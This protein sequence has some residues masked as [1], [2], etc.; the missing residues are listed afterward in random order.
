MHNLALAYTDNPEKAKQLY[1][2]VLAIELRVQPNH[3]ITFQ[4]MRNLAYVYFDLGQSDSA[5]GLLRSALEGRVR[6]LGM[7]H[8]KTQD[9]I[10]D[11]FDAAWS[12]RKHCEQLV[13]VLEQGQERA[14]RELGPKSRVTTSAT[15]CLSTFLVLLGRFDEATALENGLP[16]PA[17]REALGPI[18]LKA[19]ARLALALRERGRFDHGR[20]LME[21]IAAEAPRLSTKAPKADPSSEQVR[22]LA[23][24]L[25]GRWPGLAP[26]ISRA[27]RPPAPFTIEAPFRAASPVADGRIAPGEY[28]PAIEATFDGDT[29][30]GRVPLGCKPKTP[31]D[32]SMR[33]YTAYT[34]RSLFL[35]FQVRDQVIVADEQ[36]ARHPWANDSVAVFING[37]QVANDFLPAAA[38]LYPNGSREGFQIGA[39]ARAH[40]YTN[41]T[42]TDADRK[43]GTS[44]TPDG[45]IVEFEIPLALIDTRDGPEYVPATSGSE[46]LVNFL[47][48]DNDA[49]VNVAIDRGIFWAEDPP[50]DPYTGGE[51]FWTVALRLVPKHAGP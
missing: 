27:A 13:L 44:R 8:P 2:Q 1:E 12:N 43:V 20:R 23:Q 40:Q 6:I 7:L 11:F 39:D 16:A 28:G 10:C 5:I 48:A 24:F 21:E 25:L 41:S 31:D 4:T 50:L 49:P 35:A 18:E 3:P 29:N 45:Y 32:L 9:S 26:G 33:L 15:D 22:G 37:D 30:P 19:R 17:D 14:R 38:G 47:V 34:D 46:L 42:F 51:D 36:N